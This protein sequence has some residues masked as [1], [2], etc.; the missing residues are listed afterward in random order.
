MLLLY[1]QKDI[2]MVGLQFYS[3]LNSIYSFKRKSNGQ[4]EFS[5]YRQITYDSTNNQWKGVSI[6]C[7]ILQMVECKHTWNT[8]RVH[9][10][11][12]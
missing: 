2:F 1:H 3:K 6:N 11:T 5:L 8:F 10:T 7:V 12:I 4:L 9:T